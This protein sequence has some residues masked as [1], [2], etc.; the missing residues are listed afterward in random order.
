MKNLNINGIILVLIFAIA[1]Y[2]RVDAY[3]INNSFFT[4]EILLAQNIFERNY[5]GLFLPLKYFQSAPYLF[6]VISKFISSTLGINEL[7]FRWFPLISSLV[8][9][10]LF[11]LLLK[12]YFK[13]FAVKILGLF[14]F[15]IS[16]QLLFYSQAFKQYSSDVLAAIFILLLSSKLFKTELSSL[17]TFALGFVWLICIMLSFP[18]Y[19]MI[20]AFFIAYII[21]KKNLKILFSLIIPALFSIF[22]YIFNLSK[23]GASAYLSDYWQKGFEIFSPGI[24]KLNFDFLFQYYSFPILFLILL[25]IGFCYLYKYNRFYFRNLSFSIGLTLLAALL[26]IYPFER[27]LCLFLL[28]V[29]ILITIYPLD[30][31]KDNIKSKLILFAALIFFGFG[32]FNFAKEF[33]RGNVSYLRQDVK[34]LLGIVLQKKESEKIYLYYGSLTA[35]S[36]YSKLYPLPAA[37]GGT[38]PKDEKVSEKYLLS[39]LSRLPEG[40]YY[41]LFV[42]GTWTFD[43]DI[44][45]AKKWFNLN[46]E[47]ADE[48]AL[49]SAYLFK[50]KIK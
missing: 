34:P 35:Y 7:C 9:V 1:I 8:S 6:L 20:A 22:Y 21:T 23:V 41:L 42:K 17:K 10:F 45:A 3:L 39:D 50:I 14:T 46:A 47:I 30:N 4:D 43:K 27:R 24:Y 28:P 31:L 48:Y 33:V 2:L 44:E 18:A 15:A 38:Y 36:Y 5:A 11:Y 40:V 49:K 29:L 26:K 25:I 12:E 37:I 13:N 32:Y 19:I 16:Y